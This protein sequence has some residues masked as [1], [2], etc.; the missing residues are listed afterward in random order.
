MHESSLSG[1]ARPMS[2]SADDPSFDKGQR[3]ASATRAEFPL[4]TVLRPLGG[5]YV[6]VQWDGNILETAHHRDLRRIDLES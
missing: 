4:G 6:L 3:V 2:N 1:P 5:G